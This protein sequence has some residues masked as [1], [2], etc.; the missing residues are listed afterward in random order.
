MS[1]ERRPVVTRIGPLGVVAATWVVI[2]VLFPTTEPDAMVSGGPGGSSTIELADGAS[3]T[4]AGGRTATSA[5]SGDAAGPA[6]GAGADAGADA[7][8]GAAGGDGAGDAPGAPEA[9]AAGASGTTVGGL[10]CEPGVRQ[11]PV[12]TYAVPC[13]PAWSGDNGGTTARGVTADEIVIV[14]RVFPETANSQ[15]VGAVT[16]Q[17]GAASAEQQDAIFEVFK[18]YL[19]DHYELYGRKVRWIRYESRFG[20]ST[21]EAQSKGREAACLD[22]GVVADELGAFAV[23]G[24]RAAPVS[25]PFA[26]CAAQRGVAVLNGAAYFPERFYAALHPYVWAFTM[27]CE[28][29]SYQVAEYVGKRLAGKPAKW[30]GDPLLASQDRKFATYVPNNDEYQHCVDITERVGKEQY[31]VPASSR[32]NYTLDVSRFPD[33][34][35]RGV[36]QFKADGATTVVMACDPISAIFLTQSA[37]SQAYY[38]EW[39]LIGTALQDTDLFAQ[40]YDQDQAD[41]HMFGMSQLGATSKIVGPDSEPGRLYEL[42][43]GQRMVEGA[44]GGYSGL[45][46]TYNFLQ[47]AGPGLT[48]DAIAT[49]AR[50]IPPG[51]APDF[52]LGYWSFADGPDG[53]AGAGDHTAVDDSREIYWTRSKVSPENG[54]PGTFV[55]TYG[56]Q[57]FRNGEWP[58]EDPPIYPGS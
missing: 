5:G 46:L 51:G 8:G 33:E 4:A 2:A 35:A 10:P 52:S 28:R 45:I 14:E 19:N 11:I 32:Y 21:D 17:A 22:A 58:A 37:T 48:A 9:T 44:S 18:Q 50:T 30:A 20:S 23:V 42:I 31:G 3:G 27:E 38:P 41:G 25:G 29:I 40:L 34:A 16:E 26:E 13:L 54:T 1:S 12:S 57:R 53:T 24:T 15:A 55:E 39:F 6:T 47:A 49:G 36:V 56:G 7:A 43:T